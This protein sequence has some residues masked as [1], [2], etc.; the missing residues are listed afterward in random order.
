M[1]EYAIRKSDG[2]KIKIGTC[3]EMYY[4]RYSDRDKVCALPGNVDPMDEKEV[5]ELRWRLPYPEE[6]HIKPGEYG[7][8]NHAVPLHGFTPGNSDDPGMFRARSKYGMIVDLPCYH[9]EKL[10]VVE[11]AS[12]F[13]NGK[14]CA[15]ELRF[16]K[17]IEGKPW[18]VYGCVECGKQ[19]R[20]PLDE[21][22]PHLTAYEVQPLKNRLVG[23]YL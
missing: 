19:W 15:Y 17:F 11:G 9:G 18:G 10:P 16:L 1:G 20:A 5:S 4:L 8:Y 22:V 3:E 13:W 21:I 12:F 7:D 2:L 14:S 6:D 23:W